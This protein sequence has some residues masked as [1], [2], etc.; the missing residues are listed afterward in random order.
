M[1]AEEIAK[2]VLIPEESNKEILKVAITLL[3]TAASVLVEISPGLYGLPLGFYS[4]GTATCLAVG[5]P[6]SQ[7][8]GFRVIQ[9]LGNLFF[10][11]LTSGILMSFYERWKN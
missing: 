5:C 4:P 1:R 10:W 2:N 8:G 11:Y 3:I 7:S 6:Q 9:L